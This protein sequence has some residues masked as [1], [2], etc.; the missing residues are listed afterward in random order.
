MEM[1]ILSLA[2]QIM[3]DIYLENNN[4]NLKTKKT[5]DKI[6]QRFLIKK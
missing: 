2:K 4:F 1:K 6:Q 5:D 3:C